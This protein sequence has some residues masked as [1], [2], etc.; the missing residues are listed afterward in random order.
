MLGSTELPPGGY[1]KRLVVVK[2]S[3]S[4]NPLITNT[5]QDGKEVGYKFHIGED[6]F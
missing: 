2:K 4:N 5:M 1:V 6:I 3:G